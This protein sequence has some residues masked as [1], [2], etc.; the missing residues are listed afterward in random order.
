MAKLVVLTKR[1]PGLSREDFREHY[2]EVHKPLALKFFKN[3]RRYVRNYI[4][5]APG[6]E[7]PEFDCIT[8]IWYDSVEAANAD[9][10]LWKSEAGEIVSDDNESFQDTSRSRFWLVEEEE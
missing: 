7:E 8:E 2:E 9:M 4:I 10:R 6:R 5:P 3:F 1:K